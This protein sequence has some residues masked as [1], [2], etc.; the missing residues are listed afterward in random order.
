MIHA[1]DRESDG[2]A[3]KQVVQNDYL[4]SNPY[5]SVQPLS[6]NTQ[7]PP[8]NQLNTPSPS[9]SPRSSSPSL[10]LTE[11]SEGDFDSSIHGS[12]DNGRIPP[13]GTSRSFEFRGPFRG[14]PVD[15]EGEVINGPPPISKV[16][17]PHQLSDIKEER[18]VKRKERKSS[19]DEEEK[20]RRL[21]QSSTERFR[22]VSLSRDDKPRRL[23]LSKEDREEDKVLKLSPKAIEELTSQP[24]SLPL[25]S[26]PMISQSDTKLVQKSTPRLR[27][28]PSFNDKEYDIQSPPV[29][30]TVFASGSSQR[31]PYTRQP[32]NPQLAR[33]GRRD[34]DRDARPSS[35]SRR[36]PSVRGS[37]RSDHDPRS[38]VRVSVS[39][40]RQRI[41]SFSAD[42]V[43]PSPSL[44]NQEI[45]L[46]PL[47][48]TYLQLEL[49]SSR[50]S[51]LYIHRPRGADYQFESA[52]LKFERLV[53]FLYV[54]V[55]F[56][57]A[58]F[59]GVLSC[60]DA[61]LYTFT[62]LPLRFA[63]AVGILVAWWASSLW[64]EAKFVAGFVWNAV[65]RIWERQKERGR[66]FP[67]SSAPPSRA[68]SRA[69][70][71]CSRMPLG[72]PSSGVRTHRPSDA[73]ANGGIEKLAAERGVRN[74]RDTARKHKRTRSVPSTLSSYHK[75]DILQGLVIIFSCILLM[76]LDASRMYHSIRAQSAMKLYVIYNVLEVGDRLLSAVGQD[77][78]ECMV[79]DE[80]LGRDLDGRSRLL[81][82]LG[83]FLLTLV[84]NA[85]H[86]TALF[87]QV[88]TLN[89][90][91]NSYSNSLF[92]LLLSN[93]F[94]EIK[95][96]V[97]K[98]IEKTNLFQLFCADIVERFQLW[99]MLVIIGMRNIVEVGGLSIA[100]SPF[101]SNAATAAASNGT[102]PLRST[103]IPN[104]FSL[105]PSWSGE[106]LTPFFIVLGSEI[107]VD[108]V[109]HCFVAKFNNVKPSIYRNFLDILARDYYSNAFV[110]Q[111]L[112]KR[113]GLPV[114]PLSCLFIRASVQTYHMFLA[115]HFPPPL[116]SAVTGVV[117]S[118]ATSPSPAT[119]KAMEGLDM[120][121]RKALGR[122]TYGSSVEEVGREWWRWDTDDVIA[123]VAMTAFFL[124]AFLA[125][126]A[127]K[128]VLGM[129]LLRWARG[130]Y[131]EVEMRERRQRQ[132][133][134]SEV[135]RSPSRSR[136]REERESDP[137]REK[138]RDVSAQH[139]AHQPEEKESFDTFGKRLGAF[140]VVELDD[141]KKEMIYADDKDGLLELKKREKKWKDI[142]EKE[143]KEGADFDSVRRYEMVGKRIW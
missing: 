107:A 24:D 52:K 106:V 140:G 11:N 100:S 137:S 60:L 29:P 57:P 56:E 27:S 98:R 127:I 67:F 14:S 77:I 113:L 21:S 78:L 19:I 112:T 93:Q 1:D 55:N 117:Q 25:P 58:M 36:H 48:S 74:S 132:R 101:V 124:G 81:R 22:K 34:R 15:S 85:V 96:T 84:Y 114:I 65:P 104:A 141:Q 5:Q 18:V 82:P 4:A 75:A 49:A 12:L 6:M 105:I 54:P 138:R 16:L 26:I 71:E 31:Q 23:S 38:S 9:P 111:N 43:P 103:L 125:L 8:N 126:L 45:P 86:A 3:L 91:V 102:L 133:R 121:I 123:W 108:W 120:V 63:K 116:P 20:P 94:V 128:L 69:P 119:T 72:V 51:P 87:Y 83:M 7:L 17:L 99:I 62:I 118:G 88:I 47:M 130:R 73:S 66:S 42:A 109:K 136:R 97:F 80:T 39:K 50:P 115:A 10:V 37:D 2:G 70:S 92:T 59:F 139:P 64:N 46:P 90:A 134:E 33:E 122:A 28:R 35:P 53:N 143:R 41:P 40:Q 79:S 129:L 135:L 89:V 95:G 68:A 131:E 110:D 30:P 76:Q 32:S 142:A 44:P 13:N 61:W